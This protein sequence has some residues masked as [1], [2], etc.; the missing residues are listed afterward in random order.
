MTMYPLVGTVDNGGGC[1]CGGTEE[2]MRNL[3]TFL[4]FAVN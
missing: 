2:Y 4:C 3:C 1:A